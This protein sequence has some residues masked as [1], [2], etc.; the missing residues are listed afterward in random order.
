MQQQ[1]TIVVLSSERYN[2]AYLVL[3][4]PLRTAPKRLELH[5]STG[6]SNAI[7]RRLL[8]GRFLL[9]VP[10]LNRSSDTHIELNVS[11]GRASRPGADP[12]SLRIKKIYCS[13]SRVKKNACYQKVDFQRLFAA[14]QRD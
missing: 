13:T 8:P 9:T 5:V 2:V 3:D 6:E 12:R 14:I 1:S 11:F 4:V 10:L 7:R